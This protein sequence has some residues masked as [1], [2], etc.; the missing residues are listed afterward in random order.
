[1]SHR[2]QITLTDV[3]YARL[4]EESARSGMALAE[5]VRRALAIAYGGSSESAALDAVERSFG[6]WSDRTMD[7]EGYVDD[8]RRGMARRLAG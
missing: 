6:A 1:M 5:L 7:G 2:T 8:L 4:R 3:Q